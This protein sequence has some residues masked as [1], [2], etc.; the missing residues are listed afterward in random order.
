MLTSLMYYHYNVEIGNLGDIVP[1][2][3][4]VTSY[5][6]DSCPNGCGEWIKPRDLPIHL[7]TH[8]PWQPVSCPNEC[9]A[10]TIIVR[11]ELASHMIQC[12]RR[13]ITCVDCLVPYEFH[14]EV[15]HYEHTCPNRLVT[16]SFPNCLQQVKY[17]NIIKHESICKYRLVMCN[18]C[19]MSNIPLIQRKHHMDHLCLNRKIDC[20]RKCQRQ[21]I[22]CQLDQHYETCPN[23][24]ISCQYC[25][26]AFTKVT[27]HRHELNDCI[28]RYVNCTIKGCHDKIQLTRLQEHIYSRC[29]YRFI[30]C[31]FDCKMKVRFID[32]KKHQDHECMNRLVECP[33]QC[34]NDQQHTSITT[35]TSNTS[36]STSSQS[37]SHLVPIAIYQS[38]EVTRIPMKQLEIHLKYEC[39]YRH[40]KCSLCHENI[41]F[42]F[43]DK[44]N[45][46]CTMK[47][48]QCLRGKC[49]KEFPR[50]DQQLHDTKYCKYRIISCIEGCGKEFVFVHQSKHSQ[51]E[52]NMRY[53]TCKQCGQSLREKYFQD[54]LE[55]TCIVISKTN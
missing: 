9:D 53:L 36:T 31:P 3:G 49:R 51:D 45:E 54:H 5:Q 2:R 11:K 41:I 28:Y 25:E 34:F 23:Y 15:N 10:S 40:V 24:I 21:V 7:E 12:P 42:K 55:N 22:F 29:N 8:C 43:L 18:Q 13:I 35:I 19:Y 17:S 4:V 32:L 1:M 39:Y 30:E 6:V 44:H 20:P 26:E 16:C 48:I 37:Q 33:N 47:V 46:E 50:K 14:H 27:I 38:F 52:C